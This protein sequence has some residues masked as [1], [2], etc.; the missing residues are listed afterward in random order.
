MHL[1]LVLHI[2]NRK[3][4]IHTISCGDGFLFQPPRSRSFNTPSMFQIHIAG[5]RHLAS[6][7]RSNGT[8]RSLRLGRNRVGDK[9]ARLLAKSIPHAASL[10]VLEFS[11]RHTYYYF[12]FRF[13]LF[14]VMMILICTNAVVCTKPFWIP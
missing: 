1:L 14:G 13:S 5:A 10:T 7:I 12:V 6:A 2:R 8:L 11:D 9:G 4:H 3:P